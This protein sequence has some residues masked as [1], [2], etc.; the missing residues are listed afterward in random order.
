MLEA[1]A[2]NYP[3]AGFVEA[4]ELG[5]K[6]AHRV[7]LKIKKTKSSL[8]PAATPSPDADS[9]PLDAA[10]LDSINSVFQTEAYTRLHDTFTDYSL[11]KK[12]RDNAITAIRNQ[13]IRT[14]TKDKKKTDQMPALYNY[15]ALSGLFSNFTKLVVRDLCLDEGKRVDGR[16]LTELRPIKCL[17]NMYPCLHGSALFQ[18]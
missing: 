4:L 8:S 5:V 10:E 1:W 2:D 18:R 12:A 7:A 6:E 14:L 11:D 3:Q 16:G 17:T 13:A 9:P 15:Q